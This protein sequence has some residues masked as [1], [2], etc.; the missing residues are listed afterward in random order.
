MG[1]PRAFDEDVVIER[2]MES[3]WTN[4]YAGTS[5][6]QLAEATGIAKG[7]LYNAFS[8]KRELFDRCLDF[9]Q[10]QISKLAQ[11]LLLQPGTARDCIGSA[12]R[13][14][15]DSDLA[16]P[17]RRGCLIGNTAVELAGH[18]ADLAQKIQR[19]QSESTGWFMSRLER[20]QLDGDVSKDI[21]PR[22]YAEF[23]ATTLA[24]LRVMAMT[25]DAPVLYRVIDTTLSTL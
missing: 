4:G 15:V 2:A 9:Y 21:D 3:F 22:A 5:P 19:M 20:G 12:L 13:F 18:D 6:S 7:S 10:E 1:R 8:S 25:H 24:G 14:V 17:L 16:Q 23:L 11:E